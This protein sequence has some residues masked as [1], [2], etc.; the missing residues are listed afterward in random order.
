MK[1]SVRSHAREYRPNLWVF[2]DGDDLYV[3]ASVGNRN[4]DPLLS[5]DVNLGPIP[6][7]G[8]P[9]RGWRARFLDRFAR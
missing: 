5:V 1:V 6:P 2:S 8:A 9:W 7:P 3:T 4:C